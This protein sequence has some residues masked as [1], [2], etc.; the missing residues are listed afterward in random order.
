MG[1]G[2]GREAWQSSNG[3][4]CRNKVTAGAWQW[5][6]QA[7]T[8]PLCG[9]GTKLEHPQASLREPDQACPRLQRLCVQP[10]WRTRLG[11]RTRPPSSR[12]L[13][14]HGAL[15]RSEMGEPPLPG[16][17]KFHLRCSPRQP[18]PSIL[19]SHFRRRHHPVPSRTSPPTLPDLPRLLQALP[20]L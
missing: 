9:L 17:S 6:A 10:A 4:Y 5:L 3:I 19:P 13:G 15:L 20:G 14:Q 18:S 11:L 16:P 7:V 12:C 1:R 8:C 2:A